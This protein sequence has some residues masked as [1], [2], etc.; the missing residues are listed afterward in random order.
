MVKI[1][2]LPHSILKTT[3]A[4]PYKTRNEIMIVFCH[5]CT[6]SLPL[7]SINC[8]HKSLQKPIEN[9]DQMKVCP[10]NE[11][12]QICQ[13]IFRLFCCCCCCYCCCVFKEV[14]L[15]SLPLYLRYRKNR[16]VFDLRQCQIDF[17][18]SVTWKKINAQCGKIILFSW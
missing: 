6:F 3:L 2:K 15:L 11:L 12:K 4:Q 7:D 1:V 16:K 5:F 18:F 17:L 13:Q 14:Q 10:N 9:N 8:D